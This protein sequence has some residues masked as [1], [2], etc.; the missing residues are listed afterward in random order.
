VGWAWDEDQRSEGDLGRSF[1]VDE[2]FDR[3]DGDA[4][5]FLLFMTLFRTYLIPQ[6][7]HPSGLLWIVGVGVPVMSVAEAP[8]TTG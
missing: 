7:R 5:G 2:A 3:I 6:V 4:W 8:L 1:T